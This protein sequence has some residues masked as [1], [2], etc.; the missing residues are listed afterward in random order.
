MNTST[1]S[2]YTEHLLWKLGKDVALGYFRGASRVPVRGPRENQSHFTILFLCTEIKQ[3]MST[4]I[5]KAYFP[6]TYNPSP[7]DL[8][9]LLL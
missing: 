4:G 8:L 7:L 9:I 2:T 1:S 6:V 5:Q 3:R